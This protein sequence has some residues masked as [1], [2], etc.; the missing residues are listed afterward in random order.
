MTPPPRHRAREALR[1]EPRRSSTSPAAAVPLPTRRPS[2]QLPPAPAAPSVRRMARELGI[3][4]ND[5]PGTGS[6]GRISAEDVKTHVNR[7]VG[8][9]APG[10]VRRGAA[11]RLQPMGRDR[12]AADARRPP[13]DRAA[14]CGRMGDH[15]ARHA[16][17]SGRHHGARRASQALRAAGGGRRRKP[18][19]HRDR[20]EGGRVGTEGRSR[21]STSRS[22]WRR[23]RSSR[24]STSTSASRWIPIAA[25]SCR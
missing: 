7:L 23:R 13:Q 4:I 8:A 21:S 5:V 14:P 22:T 18:D 20:R 2:P 6:G 10:V 11:A 24:S 17:R 19:G 16:A 15:S 25:C 1:P 12:T 3:D 9:A